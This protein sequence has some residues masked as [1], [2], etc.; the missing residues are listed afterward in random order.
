MTLNE[1]LKQEEI[2][3][4]HQKILTHVKDRIVA[5]RSKMSEYYSYWD[6]QAELYSSKRTPTKA[7]IQAAEQGLPTGMTIPL[8]YAQV[9]TFVAFCYMLL[10]QKD[11]FY[12]YSGTGDTDKAWSGAA[13][14]IVE[15]DFQTSEGDRLVMQFLLDVARFS[16]G[17]LKDSWVEEFTYIPTVNVFPGQNGDP[18]TTTTTFKKVR[19]FQGNRLDVVSPYR[20]FP[21]PAYPIAEWKKGSFV[22]FEDE[23]SKMELQHL[24]SLGSVHGIKHV[25]A[26]AETNLKQWGRNQMRSGIFNWSKPDKEKNIV[27]RTEFHTWL[28]PSEFVDEDMQPLGPETF[29]VRYVIW[30]ANDSRVIKCEPSNT[31]HNQ[32]PCSVGQFSADINEFSPTGLAGIIDNLQATISWFI[33][34]RVASVSR[35]IDNQF[36]VDPT[37]IEVSSIEK[38]SRII[39]LRKSAARTDVRR[40]IT[41][42]QVQDTTTGH[43]GDAN[44]L[45]TVMQM[46][47]GVNDNAMGQYNG[48]RRSATEARSV[49]QGAA[50]RMKL[51][52]DILWTCAFRPQSQ[53]LLLNHRQ[54]LSEDTFVRIVGESEAGLYPQFHGTP[55]DL[56]QSYDTTVYDGSLPS[57][58]GFLAQSLQE[59]LS[60]LLTNPQAALQFNL[61]PNRILQGIYK[62]R[63]IGGLSQFKYDPQ[64]LLALQQQQQQLALAQSAGNQTPNPGDPTVPVQ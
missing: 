48:G 54:A 27:S 34:S 8:T 13:D 56:A 22:G 2:S 53:R 36:I 26:F 44:N 28:V 20:F 40:Y 29:P 5:S 60:I 45:M 59:L 16:I 17:I 14:T 46:V 58:K 52:L 4:L 39:L 25:Q 3:P 41:Q 19:T 64:Q 33:N 57:E 37:G 49:V 11:T 32:Y 55:E 35:T 9:N 24:E 1:Q 38:R 43:V 10:K 12:G 30:V 47:S 50:S 31:I 18:D 42:V 15:R 6:K 23:I 63:G 21:D 61:D 7:D 51:V 62:L